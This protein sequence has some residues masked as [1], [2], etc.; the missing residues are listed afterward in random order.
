MATHRK[1]HNWTLQVPS[2]CA[3]SVVCAAV[4]VLW[5]LDGFAA[6]LMSYSVSQENENEFKEA[7]NHIKT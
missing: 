2:T 6:A 1:P 5:T 4:G 7:N 3:I